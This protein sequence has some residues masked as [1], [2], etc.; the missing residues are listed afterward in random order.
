MENRFKSSWEDTEAIL[1]SAEDVYKHD[2]PKSVPNKELDDTIKFLSLLSPNS[3]SFS[4]IGIGEGKIEGQILEH[5][6]GSLQDDNLV[7]ALADCN[8]RGAKICVCIN[9]QAPK[10]KV[11][12]PAQA[13]FQDDDA[14]FKGSYDLSPSLEVKTSPGRIQRIWLV[15]GLT[16]EERAGIHRRLVQNYGSD[17]NKRDIP[18]SL[19]LPGFYHMKGEPWLVTFK[20]D[21]KVYTREEVL[22]AFPPI[23]KE[24]SEAK[25]YETNESWEA[26]KERIKPAL[27]K[28]PPL[29]YDDWVTAGMA[30]H[31]ESE[32]S[33][34]GLKLWDQW[35]KS[36]KTKY[37]NNNGMLEYKWNCSFS[38]GNADPVKAGWIFH[39]AKDFGFDNNQGKEFK[40]IGIIAKAK[41]R[42]AGDLAI[43]TISELEKFFASKGHQPSMAQWDG[44]HD[45][46]VTLEGMADGDIDPLYYLCSLDPGV[47]KTQTAVHFIKT[48]MKSKKHKDL[49][50][51][52]FVGR[53]KEIT[54]LIKDMKLAKSDFAVLVSD[55]DEN[56]KLNA[57]GNQEKTEAR[58]L[59]TTQQMLESRSK[60]N[61]NSFKGVQEFHYQGKPR[62]VKI[63]D[64]SCL[65]ARN[66][67]IKVNQIKKLLDEALKVNEKLYFVLDGLIND[68]K[69]KKDGEFVDIPDFMET[70]GVDI[71]YANYIYDDENKDTKLAVND[72]WLLSGKTVVVRGNKE[73]KNTVL[74]YQNTLPN[75]LKPMV[76]CDASGRVRQTYPHWANGRGDLVELR[77]ATKDYDQLT[78][79]LW[80]R[81]AAKDKWIEDHEVLVEGIAKTIAAKPIGEWLIVHRKK[82]K[83][84]QVDIPM[85]IKNGLVK[86]GVF[87]HSKL[88]FIHWNG[89]DAKATNKF[90]DIKNI[91]LAGTLFYETSYYEATGRAASGLKSNV[92]FDHRDYNEIRNGE[93]ASDILQAVLRGSARGCDQHRCKPCDVYVIAAPQTGV[94]DLLE[95]GF[96]FPRAVVKRF[97]PIYK[98]PRGRVKEAVDFIVKEMK[99]KEELRSTP[100]IEG[101]NMDRHDFNKDVLNHPDFEPA[102]NK[103]GIVVDRKR[104]KSGAVYKKE[105]VELE[106]IELGII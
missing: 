90:K 21:G 74:D 14:G 104:G 59:F 30:L 45:L 55:G 95:S 65:P 71:E 1:N 84:F 36:C 18:R 5:F 32:G 81:G 97:L 89:E 41:P 91:M 68:V 63:W 46:A 15:D 69:K 34:D 93:H 88:N 80:K 77:K 62:Q 85:L 99:T 94:P 73:E 8:S 22:A 3:E 58:V 26:L 24:K 17:W 66:V 9:W 70:C 2:K 48:L 7:K 29:E 31:W 61:D 102:L 38:L 67:L 100:V 82:H 33:D 50:V 96:I 92:K 23:D 64:E 13:I 60:K 103:K 42:N 44:L 12:T 52:M 101:L 56:K 47:G 25:E 11:I 79:H 43:E 16:S 35:S 106:E 27:F 39:R 98:E 28:I 83:Y 105:N 4:F 54:S 78:I 40:P 86:F 51:I 37:N 10:G 6:S 20:G 49:S 19:R 57:M 72:L 76:I 75:D 87:D 53:K